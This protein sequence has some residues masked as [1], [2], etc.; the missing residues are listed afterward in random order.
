MLF[1]RGKHCRKAGERQK[2]GERDRRS[3]KKTGREI[4]EIAT[5]ADIIIHSVMWE[6]ISCHNSLK[7]RNICYKSSYNSL[8]PILHF[9]DE[10]FCGREVK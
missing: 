5:D 8:S 7:T 2:G 4:R 3:E 9:T 10:G 1:V 6:N